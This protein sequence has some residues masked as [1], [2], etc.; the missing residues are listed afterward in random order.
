MPEWVTSLGPTAGCVVI[1]LAFLKYL[2]TLRK[3][4]EER[5]RQRSHAWT[6]ATVN[7]QAHALQITEKMS[8]SATENR[9]VI[10]ANTNQLGRMEALMGQRMSSLKGTVVEGTGG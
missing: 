7:S 1:T 5:E 8:R 9:R 10:E 6:Q 4:D 3:G 2:N